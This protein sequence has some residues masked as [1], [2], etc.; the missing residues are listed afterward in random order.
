MEQENFYFTKDI[1]EAIK[2]DCAAL[3]GAKEVGHFLWPEM[4]PDDAAKK[5]ANCLNINNKEK[6]SLDQW[7]LIS[8]KAK[9]IG[10]HNS[11]FFISDELGYSRPIPIEPEDELAELQKQFIQATEAMGKMTARMEKLSVDP[12]IQL[13]RPIKIDRREA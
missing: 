9:D 5:L 8:K 3:G 7:L 6:L 4:S 10:S 12:A 1:Y 2:H 11:V 13:K